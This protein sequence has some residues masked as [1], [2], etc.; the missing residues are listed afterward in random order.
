MKAKKDVLTRTTT[1][2]FFIHPAFRR[3]F[4]IGITKPRV[5]FVTALFCSLEIGVYRIESGACSFDVPGT[6]YS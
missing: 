6:G 2:T 3:L 4:L 1:P 5:K